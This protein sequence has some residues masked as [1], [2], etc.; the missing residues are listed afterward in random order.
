MKIGTELVLSYS[1]KITANDFVRRPAKIPKYQISFTQASQM[2]RTK[3]KLALSNSQTDETALKL[4]LQTAD[5]RRAKCTLSRQ[6]SAICQ[7]KSGNADNR[8]RVQYR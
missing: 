6:K 7:L 1:A 5:D 3:E 2:K 8:I 4:Q